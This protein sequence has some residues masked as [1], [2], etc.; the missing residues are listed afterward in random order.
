MKYLGQWPLEFVITPN[1][2]TLFNLV[3]HVRLSAEEAHAVGA[4]WP[5]KAY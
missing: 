4:N 2:D 3:F 5:Q 1:K